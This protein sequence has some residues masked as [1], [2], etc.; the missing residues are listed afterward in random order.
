MERYNYDKYYSTVLDISARK[1][2]AKY[3]SKYFFK[4]KK[5]LDIGCGDGTFLNEIIKN[6]SLAYGIENGKEIIKKID[7]DNIKIYEGD[8]CSIWNKV[9]Q[10]FDGIFCSHLIEHLKM[11]KVIDLIQ[12]FSTKITQGGKVVLVFPNPASIEMQLFHFWNDPQHVR[13][14]NYQF[15]G[16][17][18]EHYG[19]DLIEIYSKGAWGLDLD[20]KYTIF[21]DAII[22]NNN[23]NLLKKI[24]RLKNRI[25][26][27]MSVSRYQKESNYMEFMRSQGR[28]L[29]IIS[30]KQ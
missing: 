12:G 17:V 19:F 29:V 6:N 1:E 8:A 28:E 2:H 24:D 10:N 30:R 27:F 11:E 23:K 21:N 9:N 15:I 3:F 22:G 26:S 14:Y 4:C 16:S 20:K 7:R 25:K 13:Y 5:V 18:L